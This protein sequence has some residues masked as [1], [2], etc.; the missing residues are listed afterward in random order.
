MD[1]PVRDAPGVV[2]KLIQG[3]PKEQEEAINAYFT[4]DAEFIHPFCRTGSFEGS[5]L[6]IHAI[7]RW[8]KIMSPRIEAKI[9]GIGRSYSIGSVSGPLETEST[10]S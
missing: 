1:D 5:R 6:L 4:P 10:R 8:Y 9:N 7:F 3:S 2:H